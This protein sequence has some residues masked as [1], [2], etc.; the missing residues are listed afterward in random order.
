MEF[1]KTN[2]EGLYLI[3]LKPFNDLRGQLYKPFNAYTFATNAPAE[4]NT[5]IKEVW[6]TKSK[7]NVIRAMHLQVGEL[8]NCRH[9]SGQSPRCHPRHP[10]RL[11]HLRTGVRC[12]DGRTRPCGIVY[13]DWLCARLPCAARR[14]HRHVHVHTGPFWQGRCGHQIR[15]FWVRLGH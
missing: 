5:D 15:F 11:P 9:H 14:I 13:S 2:I 7:L 3:H 12:G 4:I 6:F 10:G 8:E 1:S